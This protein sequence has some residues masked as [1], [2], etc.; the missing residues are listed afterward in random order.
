MKAILGSTGMGEGEQNRRLALLEE[1]VSLLTDLVKSLI[2]RIEALEQREALSRRDADVKD[3]FEP[4][5]KEVL[6]QS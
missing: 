6:A 5:P 1:R 2:K 3:L 4:A